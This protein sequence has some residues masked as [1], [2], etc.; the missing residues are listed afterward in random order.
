MSK[1]ETMK[2]RGRTQR[3]IISRLIRGVIYALFVCC[4]FFPNYIKIEPTG[5]NYFKITLNGLYVGSVGDESLIDAYMQ[6]ARKAIVANS[7]ELIFMESNLQVEASE[8][9]FADVDSRKNIVA[10]MVRALKS[11]QQERFNRAY[12]VKVDERTINLASSDEVLSFLNQTINN[13]DS[14]DEFDA[15]LSLDPNRELA[16]LVPEIRNKEK[17]EQELEKEEEF[18]QN[19][20][21][22]AGIES[23]FT[24]CEMDADYDDG[25]DF[26]DFDYGLTAVGFDDKIEVV[27][28]YVPSVDL[29]RLDVALNLLTENQEMQQIYTVVAGDTLSG[30][31]NKTNTSIDAILAMNSAKLSS[32]SSML[33]IG[34]EIVITVPEPE[35]SVDW[36]ETKYYE[37]DYYADIQY[38]YNDSWY[39]TQTKTLQEAVPG[40]R[41]VAAQISY[42]NQSVVDRMIVYEEDVHAAVP[43]IIEKGTKVPPTYVKPLNGG[44]LTSYFGNRNAPTK[45]ASTNHK[46]IDWATPIGT[47]IYASCGGTVTKAGWGSGYGYVVY[48]KHPDGRETRYAHLSKIIVTTGQYVSQGTRIALSG[49]SGRSTGPHLHFEMLINGTHVNPLNYLN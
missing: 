5:N 15:T 48:I 14:S 34:D 38:V 19:T 12:T 40:F 39:T 33:H 21:T 18:A 4:F 41:K 24:E 36:T 47:S 28:A 16:V 42:R 2:K 13:Y 10:N 11:T 45:G 27:E 9:L 29:T 23:F 20:A 6:E 49:N 44:H 37:E 17:A 26:E 31:A 32:A 1:V 43:Q 30:I 46:G 8:E 22:Q 7:E 35:L 25:V 3:C